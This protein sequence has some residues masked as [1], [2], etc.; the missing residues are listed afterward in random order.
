[1]SKLLLTIYLFLTACELLAAN[2]TSI[3]GNKL[4]GQLQSSDKI[5]NYIAGWYII[6]GADQLSLEE[7]ICLPS[8]GESGQVIDVVKNYLINNP[9]TRHHNAAALIF[10]ALTDKFSCK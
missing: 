9:E 1:M 8:T 4:L 7:A 6:G 5:D 2:V 10:V 3:D